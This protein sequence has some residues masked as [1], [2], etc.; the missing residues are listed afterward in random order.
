MVPDHPGKLFYGL[1]S[2]VCCPPEP[3]FKVSICPTCS[4]GTDVFKKL[5][6]R[7]FASPFTRPDQLSDLKIVNVGKVFMAFSSGDLI[8]ANMCYAGKVSVLQSVFNNEINGTG[9]S[10]PRTLK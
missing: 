3:L 8:N 1:E 5:P 9:D 7:I 6:E 4:F 2:G 10:S